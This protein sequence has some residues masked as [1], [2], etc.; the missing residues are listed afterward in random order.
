MIK[1]H[2]SEIYIINNNEKNAGMKFTGSASKI[3]LSPC[4]QLRGSNLVAC[5]HTSLYTALDSGRLMIIYSISQNLPN[6]NCCKQTDFKS[7]YAILSNLYF[8]CVC[9]CINE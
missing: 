5:N 1:T 6:S 2:F 4:I 9:R 7:Y 3:Y 8:T